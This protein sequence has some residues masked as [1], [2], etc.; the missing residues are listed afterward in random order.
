M[1]YYV[2]CKAGDTGP[3]GP[4]GS[5]REEAVPTATAGQPG[6]T[7]LQSLASFPVLAAMPPAPWLASVIHSAELDLLNR[8][9]QQCSVK[10]SWL[11][12]VADGWRQTQPQD[13]PSEIDFVFD[14]SRAIAARAMAGQDAFG[15]DGSYVPLLTFGFLYEEI[16]RQRTN[17]LQMEQT[18]A[19]LSEQ[20]R[21]QLDARET[22]RSAQANLRQHEMASQQWILRAF[23]QLGVLQT[24]IVSLRETLDAQFKRLLD[25]SDAFKAAVRRRARGCG[26]Q[27][28]LTAATMVTAVVSTGGAALSVATA[29]ASSLKALQDRP[30]LPKTDDPWYVSLQNEVKQIATIMEP[31][32]SS[33]QSLGEAYGRA[34]KAIDEFEHRNDVPE[35]P[36]APSTDYAKILANKADFDQ[37]MKEFRDLPEAQ[38]YQ[39]DMDLFVATCETRNGKI[40]EHDTIVRNIHDRWASIRVFRAET[41]ALLAAQEYDYSASAARDAL[42]R[43]LDQVKWDLMRGATTLSR[44][45]EYLTGNPGSVIYDDRNVGSVAATLSQVLA[46]YRH[47]FETFGSGLESSDGLTV[48]WDDVLTDDAKTALLNGR[49]AYFTIPMTHPS[50]ALRSQA[51]TRRVYLADRSL[52]GITMHIEHQGRSPMIFR[53]GTLRTFSHVAVSRLFAVDDDGNETDHAQFLEPQDRERFVGVSPFGPWK[54]RLYGS[55]SVRRQVLAGAIA[56]DIFN[57]SV[58]VSVAQKSG[59]APDVT[60]LEAAC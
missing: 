8:D 33:I 53:D 25:S 18:L 46:S 41:A 34:Q 40:L 31:A 15:R 21:L 2:V 44:A 26:F 43:S 30:P 37:N 36:A 48:K 39:R 10:L 32:G 49:A 50:F 47:S 58:A 55:E 1:P 29:T 24:E 13:E 17:A 27:Q 22:V 52:K 38:Q 54:V 5:D 16:D 60:L 9:F 6:K 3:V 57:R 14:K 12:E 35:T 19:Q 45:L 51:T 59:D 56:F 28:I 42:A 4:S 11:V 23:D 7:S 20:A